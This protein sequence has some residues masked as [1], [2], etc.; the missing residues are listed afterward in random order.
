MKRKKNSDKDAALESLRTGW[1]LS[2]ESRSI[3]VDG[4]KKLSFDNDEGSRYGT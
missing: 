2:E 1:C 3:F 4:L